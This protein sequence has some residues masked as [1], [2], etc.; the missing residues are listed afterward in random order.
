MS[1]RGAP[2]HQL[3][4]EWVY[5]YRGHQCRNNVHFA[6]SGRAAGGGNNVVYFVAGVAIVYSVRQHSQK[7]YL[8]HDDDIISMCLH[9]DTVLVATGQVGK[10]PYICVWDSNTMKTISYLKDQHQHGIAAMSFDKCGNRLVSVGTD[11]HATINVW[12]W[13]K[14]K[15]IATTRGHNDKVFDIQ[16]NIFEENSIVSC[17]VKHIKFWNLCGNSLQAKKGVFGKTGEIQ[18]MLCLAFSPDQT[19]YAGTLSGDIYIWKG[20]HLYNTISD[21]H[22]GPVN[23]LYMGEEGY[24]TGGKDGLVKLWDGDFKLITVINM[25]T[26]PNGYRDLCVRS[27][28]WKGEIILVGTKGGEIFEV[29]VHERNKPRCLLQ[30]HAEGE[31]WALAVHPRK[32][33]FATGSDDH[34]LRIWQMSNFEILSKTTLEHKIRSCAFRHD[35]SEIAVGYDDGSFAVLKTRDMAEVIHTKDRKEVLHEM[36]Y[37][38]CGKYLAVASND[39]YVDIYSADQHYKKVSACSGS[40]SFITH[41]DWSVDSKF[42]QTNSGASERLI[43]SMPG[44]KLA[45]NREEV[46]S[47]QWA[48]FTGVLGD[49]VSGIWEKYSA[50]ND[51]NATDANLEGQLLVTG[52]DFGLVKLFRYPCFRKG[53]K[54]RKYTGHSAHV[55]NVRFSH[56]KQRVITIGGADHAV[57]QWKLVNPGESLASGDSP[58]QLE[59]NSEDSDSELSDVAALDSD[60]EAEKQVTYTRKVYQEDLTTLRR[61]SRN[62]LK[63]VDKRQNGPDRG[64]KLEY[65]HGYRSYDCRNNVFYTQSGRPVYHIAAVG[66]VLDRQNNK[67]QFYL[68]HDDDVLCLCIHPTK[69]LVATGQVGRNPSVH[70]WDTDTFKSVSILKGQHQRGI[71]AVDFSCDG[72]KLASVGLDDDH[73][74][75]VWDWK[76]GE[77]LA[78]AK[79]Y[80]D[81]VF[82]IKWNPFDDNQLVS[83]GVKHIK[84]WTQTGGGFTSHRGVFG[85]DSKICDMLCIS[86]G[87][88]VECC[89]SGGSDGNV[90]AWFGNSIQ[91]TVKAH[92]G[93]CFA[94][95]SLEKGFVTGGKD[96]NVS[97]WD[98]EFLQCLRTYSIKRSSF[99]KGMHGVLVEDFPAV[100]AVILGHGKILVGTKNGEVLE[101]EKDGPMTILTQGHKM[102]E[103]WGLDTH[104]SKKMCATVSDDKSLR[105]WDVSNHYMVNFK[106]LK[107][108][109]RC[110]SF[111]PDGSVI[112][113]GYKDGSFEVVNVD[114]MNEVASYHHRKEE[115]SDIKFSPNPGKYLAVASH[116]NFVDLYNTDSLKRVGI[117][118]G[119]SSYITHIDWDKEGRVIMVNSGAREQLFFEA[120]R[121]KRFNLRQAEVDKFHWASWTCVLGT[122]CEG[123]WPSKADITDINAT[124]LSNDKTLLATADDFGLLKIFQFPVKGQLAKFKKYTGHSAHV[125]N[126]RWCFDDQKLVTVGGADMSVMVW[127]ATNPAAKADICRGDSDDSQTD[128]D[129]EGYDS[130]VDREK[131]MDY[132]SKIYADSLHRREGIRPNMVCANGDLHTNASSVTRNLN[133]PPKV[134]NNEAFMNSKK[135]RTAPVSGLV[136]DH[137]HGYRGFDARCNLHYLDDSGDVVFHTAGVCIVQN[138]ATGTQSFYTGHTDDILCLSVNSHPRFKNTVASGQLGNPPCIHIWEA[139]SKETLS[140]LEGVHSKGTCS[141]DFS[142]TGRYLISVGLESEHKIALWKWQ[143][144]TQVACANG[145]TDRIFRAEFRPDSDHEIVSVGVK[146]VRFWTV[147]GS[148][149]VGKRGILTN[150]TDGGNPCKMQTML[151]VAFANNNTTYTG[152]L[153]GDVYVWKDHTLLRLVIKAHTGPVFSMFTTIKDGL[154]VTGGKEPL[155]AE[156]GAVK[157]W[158]QEMK[159]CRAFPLVDSGSKMIVVKSV[160]RAKGKILVGTHLNN[161]YEITEKNGITKPLVTGHGEGEV[162]GLD[163]HPKISYFITGSFDGTVRV[164]DLSTKDLKAKLHV[165]PVRAVA[166][167]PA[168]DLI[169]VGLKNGEFILLNSE[170]MNFWGKKRD[171]SASVN[172]LRFSPDGK[173]LAVGTEDKFVDFYDLTQGRN[174]SRSG[175]CKGVPSAI[176]KMDFSADSNYIKVG[177]EAYVEKIYTVPGGKL[178]ENPSITD[179]I[180]WSSWTSILGK[181]VLGIWPENSERGDVNCC[182][183]SSSNKT[184]A[185]G[186]DFG[187]VKLFE[188]PCEQKYAPFQKYIGHSA[189]VTNVHFTPTGRYLISTGGDDCSVFIWKC[190]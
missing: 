171:R 117:C 149:L 16:F 91:R 174:L 54:F 72:K 136:L 104:P 64:L 133:P 41:L 158:D 8:G 173:F 74:I 85:K 119:C 1:D 109:A 48:T 68:G 60:L 94:M 84:F 20:S 126:V 146:H 97:L 99:T 165:G 39:N 90:F 134:L 183:L 83:V 52:D 40:S 88:S 105:L 47:I 44:G 125:T 12:E 141:L 100:R 140:I 186:D 131:N 14:G 130:D 57:F 187:Y 82:V 66:I 153:S 120:P 190:K 69:N 71:C 86:F 168:G 24:V 157:L 31:L 108:A 30:G 58:L 103:V 32:P 75:V 67:Q 98:S 180:V 110:V 185:T 175:L 92:E 179:S 7:F 89:F 170:D 78:T 155:T 29:T 144:G 156:N 59:S 139:Y 182:H 176:L 96:G 63:T 55:T 43:Y 184:L 115:I 162:W 80:K 159:R 107:I 25:T 151:S 33:I 178:V 18:T 65:V 37:S 138:I 177:T 70:V 137:V 161:V 112:A 181:E 28:C 128:S 93:P 143:E 26:I 135:K 127:A 106:R 123:I 121:G 145:H 50:T 22:D 129:E 148:Q 56:D 114:T 111:S 15:V 81:K 101:I 49:E 147:T 188:F 38:P 87:K 154:I 77:K 34:T 45:M 61:M 13:K 10:A 164:W 118:K 19:T 124:S 62:E 35:G 169:A 102:G 36:K 122:T 79:G 9:P 142:S 73:T 3:R 152:A 76:R 11:P 167:S 172:D 21:V 5:G 53:S 163:V 113:V 132:S 2:D 17:G 51:I 160:C 42:L 27:V 95:H 189:H 4:L 166:Y 23:T 6:A 116:D 150:C 46:A